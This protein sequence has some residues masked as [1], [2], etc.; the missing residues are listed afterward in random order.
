M[1][2][3]YSHISSARTQWAASMAIWTSKPLEEPGS[4]GEWLPNA[5]L[6]AIRNLFPDSKAANG[7][8][9]IANGI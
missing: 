2:E 1:C 9:M 8:Q 7:R 5:L 6:A 4:P 3:P